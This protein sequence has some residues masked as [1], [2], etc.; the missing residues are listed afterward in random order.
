M[1]SED[2]LFEMIE[3]I[4]LYDWN[5]MQ[6]YMY[7]YAYFEVSYDQIEWLTRPSI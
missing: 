2:S 3:D 5:F 6:C 1:T 4:L 7:S